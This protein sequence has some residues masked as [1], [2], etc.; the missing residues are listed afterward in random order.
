MKLSHMILI[1]V[2]IF[3]VFSCSVNNRRAWTTMDSWY[4][5]P[6]EE[7]LTPWTWN[8]IEHFE[9]EPEMKNKAQMLLLSEPIVGISQQ[10]AFDFIGKTIVKPNGTEFYLVRGVALNEG[11]GSFSVYYHENRLWVYHGS[12]GKEPVPMK[13]KAL[14]TYLSNK[15]SDIFVTCGMDE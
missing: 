9:V 2:F 4:K 10:Q 7:N 3:C 11:T 1:L 6:Q 12:L 15:P 13:C 8:I 5:A 14:V